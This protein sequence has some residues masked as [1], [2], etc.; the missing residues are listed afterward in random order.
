[1]THIHLSRVQNIVGFAAEN[2]NG[3]ESV[4]VLTKAL[5]TSDQEEFYEYIEQI[6][7]TFLGKAKVF[8]DHTYQFL[9]VI[10]E[11]LSADLYVNDFPVVVII[12]AKRDIKKGELI[13]QNDI[14]DIKSLNFPNIKIEKTDKIIFCFKVGWKFGLYFDLDRRHYLEINKMWQELGS[15]YRYLQFDYIYKILESKT[16]FNEMIN[17]G[18][19]PFI[20]IIEEDYKKIYKLYQNKFDFNN[21]MKKIIDSFDK[22][23]I[24]R[25]KSKWWK[26]KI[27]KDKQ[28]LIEAGIEAYLQNVESGFIN[29]IKNLSS[30]IEGIIRINYLNETGRGKASFSELINYLINKGKAKSG[31]NYSLFLPIPFLKYLKNVFF[32]NFDLKKGNV[33]LSRHSSS[34][35]VAK[36]EDYKK[37]KALQTI[38]ILDQIYFYL[39]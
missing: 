22:N 18:W 33:K 34:H 25:I 6:S 35:G 39:S 1:M 37:M 5:L 21:R 13:S 27:F 15:L 28:P 31:S 2:V 30:E 24:E 12:R 14:A 36:P 26:N 29:C 16:K 3:K 11:D 9:I 23:R 8:I 7:N 10:H 4:E 17:D 32:A 19:F 20:E 38:L